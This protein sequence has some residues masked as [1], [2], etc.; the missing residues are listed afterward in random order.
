GDGQRLATSGPRSGLK[1]WET[2]RGRQLAS[3]SVPRGLLG[4]VACSPDGRRVAAQV[5]VLAADGKAAD[6]V[7]CWEVDTGRDATVL[8]GLFAPLTFSADGR[9]LLTASATGI[10]FWDVATKRDDHSTPV[11]DHLLA[12]SS[13]GR[14]W[15]GAA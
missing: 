7:R 1:V 15:A 3:F 10:R 5:R 11:S 4:P 2:A 14:F 12:F 8:P 9:Y 6:E 13:D